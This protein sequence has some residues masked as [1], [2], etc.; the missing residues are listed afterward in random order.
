MNIELKNT[1]V[2]QIDGTKT[3]LIGTKLAK[4]GLDFIYEGNLCECGDCNLKRVCMNLEEYAKY[5]ITN[6][7][8][9]V[10]Y[11]C[12]VHDESVVAVEVLKLANSKNS[13]KVVANLSSIGKPFKQENSNAYKRYKK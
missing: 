7:K 6:I 9:K 5:K 1:E 4:V 13:S 3:T 2:S 12:I 10:L 8:D 11:D